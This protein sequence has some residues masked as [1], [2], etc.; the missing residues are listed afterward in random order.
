MPRDEKTRP[1][2][3][4]AIR[5]FEIDSLVGYRVACANEPWLR[6]VLF[7]WRMLYPY[8]ICRLWS[9]VLDRHDAVSFCSLLALAQIEL[10]DA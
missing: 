8:E 9:S 10:P 4:A 1:T 6:V 5:V 7:A 2:L 3:A